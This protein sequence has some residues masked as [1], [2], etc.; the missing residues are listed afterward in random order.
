[1][2][3]SKYRVEASTSFDPDWKPG[4]KQPCPYG[5]DMKTIVPSEHNCYPLVISAVLPRPIGFISSMNKEGLLNL[6]PYSYFQAVSHDPPCTV[7]SA[8][9]SGARGGARK[10]TQAN[11]EETG[12]FVVNIMSEWFVEAANH[13]CG[14]FDPDVS[15]WDLCGLTPIPSRTVGHLFHLALRLCDGAPFIVSF[16]AP[17]RR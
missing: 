16:A 6:A 17:L 11:I 15:E 13:T 12:E 7:L 2:E 5:N 1:M 8:S 3:S 9:G 4:D 14:N 10:D